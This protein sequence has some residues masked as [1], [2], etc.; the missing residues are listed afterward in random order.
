MNKSVYNILVVDDEEMMRDILLTRL[1]KEP[2]FKV[3]SASNGQ[4]GLYSVSANPPDLIL[5]D[6]QMPV[7][8]GIT[9]MR[10]LRKDPKGKDIPIIFLT[11]YD[12]DENVLSKISEGKPAFYLIKSTISLDEVVKKIKESLGIS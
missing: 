8:D 7:M 9:M 4:E 6:V 1:S 10:E 12:T 3:S 5:L 11:N 2:I